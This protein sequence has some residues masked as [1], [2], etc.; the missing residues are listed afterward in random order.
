MNSESI[1]TVMLSREY[2][3]VGRGYPLLG[4]SYRIFENRAGTK[5]LKE[6]GSV[7]IIDAG[8]VWIDEHGHPTRIV[9]WDKDGPELADLTEEQVKERIEEVLNA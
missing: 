1:Y 6:D 4:F 2:P 5:I 3:I 9:L 8:G 7:E